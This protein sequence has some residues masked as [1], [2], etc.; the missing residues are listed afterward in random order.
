MASVDAAAATPLVGEVNELEAHDPYIAI[1]DRY[2][3]FR[4]VTVIEM[5]E[6]GR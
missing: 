3:D 2:R 4:V 6:N 5:D 1:L